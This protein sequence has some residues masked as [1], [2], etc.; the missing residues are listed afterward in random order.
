MPRE[1][2][3]IP[4]TYWQELKEAQ[5]TANEILVET[6]LHTSPNSTSA[7]IFIEHPDTIAH[8]TDLSKDEVETALIALD[9]QERVKTYPG[10]WVFVVNRW[11]LE[12]SRFSP[13]CLQGTDNILRKCPKE[14]QVAFH[15]QYPKFREAYLQKV[16]KRNEI[17]Y[18]STETETERNN[19]IQNSIGTHRSRMGNVLSDPEVTD[20]EA[21]ATV[22]HDLPDPP[23]RPIALKDGWRK[24]S[25]K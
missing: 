17:P 18:R 23:E 1:Y 5:L 7:G 15:M 4:V 6:Y 24:K 22:C 19:G 11:R 8:Y 12:P 21:I 13:K 2:S 25:R 20:T 16:R 10:Y 3:T 14:V 9:L